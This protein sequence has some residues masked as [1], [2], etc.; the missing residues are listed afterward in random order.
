MTVT[1]AATDY[2]ANERSGVAPDGAWGWVIVAATFMVL[3]IVK[4]SH[5]SIGLF[6]AAIMDHFDEGAGDTSWMASTQVTISLCFGPIAA[7]LSN[8]FSHRSVVVTGGLVTSMSL[9]ASAFAPNIAFITVTFGFLVGVGHGLTRGPSGAM[10][11][12]YFKKRYAIASGI[13]AVGGGFGSFVL[14][15]LQ[16]FLIDNYGWS[17]AFIVVAGIVLHLCISG[18]LLR[19]IHLGNNIKDTDELKI[20]QDVKECATH[21]S[22]YVSTN[23]LDHV[24]NRAWCCKD[25][26]SVC[27]HLGLHLF[28]D[29]MFSILMIHALLFG[30][31]VNVPA[32]HIVK[33]ADNIG[34]TRSES[35]VMLSVFGITLMISAVA[36]GF[37]VDL[38]HLCKIK[39]YGAGCFL[40]GL[41][42]IIVPA[43]DDFISM[44]V[45]MAILGAARG[46][47]AAL[48][49][50]VTKTVVGAEKLTSGYG[51]YLF[52]VGLGQLIGPVAAGYL[53]DATGN[54]DASFYFGGSC[55]V[56]SVLILLIG[57]YIV[58][59]KAKKRDRQT[60]LQKLGY[61][62][63]TIT[64][65]D[66]NVTQT[67][68]IESN[69]MPPCEE[70]L[71][72]EHV[73]SL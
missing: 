17:G 34:V 16:R 72:A 19:P 63:Y 67:T 7:V 37:V 55:V 18:L 45:V 64:K 53:Y 49:V 22:T 65:S 3:F 62:R 5:H 10:V 13:S 20:E 36:Q 43:T 69:D 47:F 68:R 31:G 50:V 27:G 41:C 11:G 52:F 73:T 25:V 71:V 14:A 32:I 57:Q 28:T 21:E 12:R 15:P 44:C 42:I 26:L 39:S 56:G 40:F 9:F 4:G 33:R 23:N 46:V 59:N 29:A 66:N 70:L 6:F 1:N 35:A 51:L 48:H 61:T 2:T 38:L 30:F 60:E 58:K 54:Y 24:I 8:R